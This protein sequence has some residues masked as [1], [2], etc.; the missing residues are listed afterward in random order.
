[1]NLEVKSLSKVII[2]EFLLQVTKN[3][4]LQ[5]HIYKFISLLCEDLSADMVLQGMHDLDLMVQNGSIC[6]LSRRKKE[7]SM[8]VHVLVFKKV[9]RSSPMTLLFTSSL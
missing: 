1:M 6:V 5:W 3:P 7:G 4:K 9:P 2:L 8:K